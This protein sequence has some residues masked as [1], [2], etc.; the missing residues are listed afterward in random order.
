MNLIK[1]IFNIKSTSKVKAFIEDSAVGFTPLKGNEVEYKGAYCNCNGFGLSFDM[2]SD[3]GIA[4]V[5]Y[6]IS[7]GKLSDTLSKKLIEAEIFDK[8]KDKLGFTT[9]CCLMGNS[10]D[11]F[12]YHVPFSRLREDVNSPNKI[13]RHLNA[14]TVPKL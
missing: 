14:K 1:E 5:D 4:G 7:I 10:K 2:H 12:R 3:S 9:S 11:G 8:P 13:A 6:F